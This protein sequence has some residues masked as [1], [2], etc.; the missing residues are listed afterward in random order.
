MKESVMI[1]T[2]QA[3]CEQR[4]RAVDVHSELAQRTAVL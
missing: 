2:E 4:H 1:K 3:W